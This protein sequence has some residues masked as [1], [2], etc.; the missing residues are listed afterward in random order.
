MSATGQGGG[1][2]KPMM[3]MLVMMKAEVVLDTSN[4]P[5]CVCVSLIDSNVFVDVFDI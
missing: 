1:Q 3:A 5:L 4:F 2:Q